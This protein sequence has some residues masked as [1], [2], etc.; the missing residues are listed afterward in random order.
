[1]TG[2]AIAGAVVQIITWYLGLGL[3]FGLWFTWKGASRLDP[4]AEASSWGFR[5]LILPGA[6]LLWPLLAVR[7]ARQRDRNRMKAAVASGEQR[8]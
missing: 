2:I 1:M 5:I 6:A 8:P 3:L 7:L 4:A